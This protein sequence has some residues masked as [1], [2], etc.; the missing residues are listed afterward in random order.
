MAF[1][2]GHVYI[3]STRALRATKFCHPAIEL[4][5]EELE[6]ERSSTVEFVSGGSLIREK[7]TYTRSMYLWGRQ[8]PKR[9]QRLISMIASMSTDL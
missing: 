3:M 7:L 5:G 8:F 2:S 1:P 6:M 4:P 9:W